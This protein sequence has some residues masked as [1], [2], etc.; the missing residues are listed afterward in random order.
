MTERWLD[1]FAGPEALAR[2]RDGS[3]VPDEVGL[4]PGA[5][6]G[7]KWFVLYGLDRALWSEFFVGRA[8]ALHLVGSSAG[9]WRFAAA[10]QDQPLVALE[11]FERAYRSQRFP[12]GPP[13]E[14]VTAVAMRTMDE[15]LGSHG[16]AEI[17]AQPVRRLA[18]VVN[19]LRRVPATAALR[20]QYAELAKAAAFNLASRRL[21]GRFVERVV[22]H[23]GEPGPLSVLDGLPTTYVPLT[24][25]NLRPALLASGSIPRVMAPVRDIP[26]AGPGIYYDGGITDYHFAHAFPETDGLVLMPHFYPHLV[27]GWFDKL[28]PWRRPGRALERTVVL[29]PSAAFLRRLPHGKIPDRNDFLKLADEDRERYWRKAVDE[30]RRLGETFLEL[31]AGKRLGTVAK[32]LGLRKH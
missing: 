27:P 23:V 16:T 6:G 22:F 19:R 11:R 18:I 12:P 21:L 28:A 9:S 2:L 26:G 5:S 20:R 29:A 15:I 7:P 30:S 32:S 3:L 4:V 8:S 14:L 17:L 13:A 10:C 1:V 24:A 31:V 25:D